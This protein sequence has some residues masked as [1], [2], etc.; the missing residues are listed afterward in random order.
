M[1][2]GQSNKM[3]GISLETGQQKRQDKTR[4]LDYGKF[5]LKQYEYTIAAEQIRP[6][7]FV[8]FHSMVTKT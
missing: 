6:I 5:K 2:E 8:C 1:M 4:T 3:H 7:E